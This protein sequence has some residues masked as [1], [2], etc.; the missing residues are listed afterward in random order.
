[1]NFPLPS[2]DSI[3]DALSESNPSYFTC[4]D[5][6]SSFWQIPLD[7]DTAEKTSFVTHSG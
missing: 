2:F 3:I 6:N 1:M 5:L 4:M 7:W